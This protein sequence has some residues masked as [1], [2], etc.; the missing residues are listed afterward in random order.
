[1]HNVQCILCVCTMS[2]MALQM[3]L[4]SISC[5]H[6]N[7]L[8][9]YKTELIS[10][11]HVIMIVPGPYFFHTMSYKFLHCYVYVRT[12]YIMCTYNVYYVYVQCRVWHCRCFLFSISC[13][14]HNILLLYKTGIL[15]STTTHV[16]IH[17]YT[18]DVREG[19]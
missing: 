8:L 1:M 15:N 13:V 18:R 16:Y 17:V 14:H 19:N 6:H 10:F 2:C 5:V 9:L 7:I 12:L 4:F 3:V 11:I